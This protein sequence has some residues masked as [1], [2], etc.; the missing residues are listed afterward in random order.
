MYKPKKES[1]KH[2]CHVRIWS[3]WR[4]ILSLF[5]LTGTLPHR[6]WSETTYLRDK[7]CKKNLQVLLQEIASWNLSDAWRRNRITA[8]TTTRTAILLNFTNTSWLQEW[9]VWSVTLNQMQVKIEFSMCQ[10]SIVNRLTMIYVKFINSCEWQWVSLEAENQQHG[11]FS[12]GY[13][14]NF[15]STMIAPVFVI[16]KHSLQWWGESHL[17]LSP[18]PEYLLINSAARLLLMAT[19]VEENF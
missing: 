15:F 4:H 16:L 19:G 2:R 13:E 12:L 14:K 3:K 6:K 7:Q 1:F 11:K 17:Y 8:T 5:W 10:L 9:K 18:V